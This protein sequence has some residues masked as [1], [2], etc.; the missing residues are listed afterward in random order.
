MA[1]ALR[2]DQGEFTEMISGAL[3]RAFGKERSAVKRIAQLADCNPRA[4]Q[5]WLEGRNAPDGLH[6]LRLAA[7]VPEMQGE[8]RRLIGMEAD[9]DPELARDLSRLIDTSVRL[10]Q[11]KAKARE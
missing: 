7:M 5:N 11:A 10:L 8:V 1:L 4:A 2:V 9:L 3:K 6:L